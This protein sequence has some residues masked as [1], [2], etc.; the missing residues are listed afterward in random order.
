M[1]FMKSIVL[2]AVANIVAEVAEAM[3]TVV[4]GIEAMDNI[5][6]VVEVVPVE[7]V[8]VRQEESHR[9]YGLRGHCLKLTF[10][11]ELL[12]IVSQ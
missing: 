2:A 4:V 5:A 11:S 10:Q 8:L 9:R 7:E 3:A 12:G 6:V 1:A